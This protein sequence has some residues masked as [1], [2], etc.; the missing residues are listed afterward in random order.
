[1]NGTNEQ[2]IS[3]GFIVHPGYGTT[4]LAGSGSAIPDTLIVFKKLEMNKD[5]SVNLNLPVSVTDSLIFKKG[6][7]VSDT[8]NLFVMKAGSVVTGA[9]DT[10]FVNGPVKKFGNTAF[11]FP[12]GRIDIYR[13]LQISAPGSSTDAFMAQY[14]DGGQI[15]GD[16]LDTIL[17]KVSYCNYWKLERKNGSSNV[18]VTLG[19]DTSYCA[20][21]DTT[22]MRLA[23]WN[24]T[25][26]VDKG[27][28]TFTGTIVSGKMT[29]AS[30]LTSF[31]YFTLA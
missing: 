18:N 10:G 30:A 12:T 15:L 1:F 24:G 27:H 21:F 3:V 14:W 22:N 2:D 23:Y 28:G 19:W 17:T 25:K 8:T 6:N 16:S 29:L 9:S 26:W 11:V 13:P 4:T 31:G 20:E 7:I 5:S